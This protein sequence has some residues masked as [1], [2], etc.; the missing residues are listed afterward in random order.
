[1]K[2]I[3]KS[4][5]M[6]VDEETNTPQAVER[7]EPL[8]RMNPC[9]LVNGHHMYVLGGILEVGDRE[10]TLDDFWAV[11]LR[12]RESWECLYKGT[13]HT[14]V[15]RGAIHDDDDSYISTGKEEDSDD[16]D[17]GSSDEE[18]LEV[19]GEESLDEKK[20]RRKSKRSGIREEIAELNEKY[21]LSD[22]NRTPNAGESLA[23][24]Y[25]RT[26][27]YWNDRAAEVVA[28]TD[29]P[30]SNKE[31]KREGFKIAKDRFDELKP[32]LDRLEELSIEAKPEKN[33][34]KTKGDGKK[35]KKGSKR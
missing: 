34:K 22:S 19:V 12:K 7:T 26:S 6:V 24:F 1:M 25:S 3:T 20:L 31:L 10:I 9:L 2:K 21:E 28:N 35:S 8:P 30:L 14:Q 5:V 15:W 33:N 23:D 13:M 27:G 18:G 29:E 17:Y 16:D 11:D 4:S 32:V